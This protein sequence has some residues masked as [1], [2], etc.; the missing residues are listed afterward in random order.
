VRKVAFRTVELTGPAEIHVRNGALLVEKEIPNS[1]DVNK[2]G[3]TANKK[4]T[5]GKGT[6]KKYAAERLDTEKIK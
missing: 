5:L 1:K 2:A 3:D 6:R 4:T